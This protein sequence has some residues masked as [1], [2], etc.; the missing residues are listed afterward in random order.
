[1]LLKSVAL[2]EPRGLWKRGRLL[3]AEQASER[4]IYVKPLHLLLADRMGVDILSGVYRP[5]DTLPTEVQSSS[6]LAISRTA[7]RET[8]RTLAA[9]GLVHTRTK[10]G[11]RVN[12]ISQWNILD[13]DVLR[14]MFEVEPNAAFVRDLFELR[15]ITEPAAAEFAA[16]RRT[17]NEIARMSAALSIMKAETLNSKTGRDADLEFH[18]VMLASAKN[19]ALASLSNSIGAAISW[20]T[21]YK[22]RHNALDRDSIPDHERVFEAIAKGDQTAAHWAMESLIRLAQA[23]LEKIKK[24]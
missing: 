3:H 4:A 11:T 7:Y 13:V 18:R 15:L 9:K 24:T 23:D 1:M 8:I 14:W 2:F 10:R 5:G 16:M 20:S 22:A 17:D 19:T 6:S 12:D 21:S